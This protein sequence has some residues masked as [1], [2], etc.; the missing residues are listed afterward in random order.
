MGKIKNKS[1]T[2]ILKEGDRRSEDNKR[3]CPPAESREL[4]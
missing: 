1:K 2:G 4:K 3:V